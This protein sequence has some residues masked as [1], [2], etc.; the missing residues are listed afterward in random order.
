MGNIDTYFTKI[1]V[2]LQKQSF[3]PVINLHTI[4]LT[5]HINR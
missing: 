3:E 2:K 5:A 1:N 4:V